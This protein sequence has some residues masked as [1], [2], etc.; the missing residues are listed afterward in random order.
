M[1]AIILVFMVG[2]GINE[3]ILMFNDK[4]TSTVKN[5][6]NILVLSFILI[7]R[8]GTVCTALSEVGN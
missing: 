7:C 2:W 6:R 4:N 1:A 5:G 8:S 3:M